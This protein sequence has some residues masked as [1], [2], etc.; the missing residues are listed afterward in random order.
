LNLK[1]NPNSPLH[2]QK[3]GLFHNLLLFKVSEFSFLTNPN[4][5]MDSPKPQT[6]SMNTYFNYLANVS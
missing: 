1:S 5:L 3:T 2:T 4:S 6:A